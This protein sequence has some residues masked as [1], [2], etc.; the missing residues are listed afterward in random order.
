MVFELCLY[1]SYLWL[2][3]LCLVFPHLL[4]LSCY[5]PLQNCLLLF[6]DHFVTL[7]TDYLFFLRLISQCLFHLCLNFLSYVLEKSLHRTQRCA[8]CIFCPD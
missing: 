2:G 7:I 6:I 5:F 4:E 8:S 3:D 1:F